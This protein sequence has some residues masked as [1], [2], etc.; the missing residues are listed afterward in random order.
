MPLPGAPNRLHGARRGGRNGEPGAPAA[1][2]TVRAC[3][4]PAA[5]Q[6]KALPVPWNAHVR[7]PFFPQDGSH[8]FESLP[9]AVND[10]RPTYGSAES[11]NPGPKLVAISMRRVSGDRVYLRSRFMLLSQDPDDLLASL[12]TAPERVLRLKAD[13]QHQVPMVTDAARQVVENAAGLDHA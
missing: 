12:N 7:H 11:P 4:R 8:G 2:R 13:E 9:L 1:Y 10:E 3:D 6:V 5:S